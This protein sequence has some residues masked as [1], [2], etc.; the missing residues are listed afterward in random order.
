MNRLDVKVF[1]EMEQLN[2]LEKLNELINNPKQMKM[3]MWLD[4]YTG[5][6]NYVLMFKTES[7]KQIDIKIKTKDIELFKQFILEINNSIKDDLDD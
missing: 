7:N 4:V 5:T 3:K 2:D 1:V 6:T